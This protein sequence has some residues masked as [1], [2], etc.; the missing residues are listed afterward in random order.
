MVSTGLRLNPA[1]RE[2]GLALLGRDLGSSDM[3]Y[4]DFMNP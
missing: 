3:I 4:A 2:N 1:D